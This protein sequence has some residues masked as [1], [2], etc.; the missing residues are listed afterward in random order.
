MVDV[1][2]NPPESGTPTAKGN[3]V[4]GIALELQFAHRLGL[5][6]G[7]V[8]ASNVLFHGDRRIQ[9]AKFSPIRRETSAFET[10]SPEEVGTDGGPSQIL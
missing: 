7:C 5:L 2:S 4:M 9:I 10:F 8:K 1:L 6:H 3:A